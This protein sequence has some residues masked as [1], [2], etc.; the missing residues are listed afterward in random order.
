VHDDYQVKPWADLQ[1]GDVGTD[2]N[3]VANRDWLADAVPLE[4]LVEPHGIC[5][6]PI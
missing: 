6:F 1:D 4:A 3:V 5:V 2:P